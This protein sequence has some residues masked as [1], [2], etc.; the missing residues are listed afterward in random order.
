MPMQFGWVTPVAGLPE[1]GGQPVVIQQLDEILPMVAEH[2]DSVWAYDHLYGFARPDEPY[3][4]C[5][6]TLTWLAARLPRLLV[7]G[8]VLCNNFRHPA[9][10]AQMGKTL[11]AFSG[12]R[13]VLGL[14]A[15]WREEEYRRYGI[16]FGSPATRVRQLEEAVQIIR[17]LWT[18]PSATFAGQHYQIDGV[19]CAPAPRPV[20]PILIGGS[21]EQLML[22]LV[23]RHA[24]WWGCSG[25]PERYAAKLEVLRRH[26]AAEGRDFDSIVKTADIDDAA[27]PADAA[28]ARELAGL[29]EQYQALGVTHL[30]FD[31]GF[32]ADAERVRRLG[33]DVLARFR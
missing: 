21:G 19:P 20:P 17:A 31:F 15:G 30:M 6:T 1:S 2:F 23:A 9:L 32:V 11:Q 5:W 33:E 4:E 14:G 29:I 12:G 8:L 13:L 28:A 16:P 24:D 26:C 10:L 25:P 22:R 18:E 7:G 3:L 27:L